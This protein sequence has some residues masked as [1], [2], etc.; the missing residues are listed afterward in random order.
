MSN[1]PRPNELNISTNDNLDKLP[2]NDLESDNHLAEFGK[3][4]AVVSL[5]T[6]ALQQ[7]RIRND[8]TLLMGTGQIWTK[9]HFHIKVKK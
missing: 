6:N 3:Q 1:L 8:C 2:V 9:G 7:K 4:A 5:G